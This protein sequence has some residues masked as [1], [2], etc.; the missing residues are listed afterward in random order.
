MNATYYLHTFLRDF[1]SKKDLPTF[2]VDQSRQVK[3]FD[4]KHRIPQPA[5][6][7][8]SSVAAALPLS[9]KVAA[10]LP[11]SSKIAAALPSAD[12]S[13]PSPSP[14]PAV[15]SDLNISGQP[16]TVLPSLQ[17]QRHLPLLTRLASPGPG[18]KTMAIATEKW[19]FA[20]AARL[21]K[22]RIPLEEDDMDVDIVLDLKGKGKQKET[23]RK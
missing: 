8:S 7:P 11:P 5:A 16:S 21:G 12:A 4:D 18:P 6:V 20:A 17:K 10:A 1:H 14:V 2:L 22:I 9:S 3:K 19:S 15:S 23:K 13:K